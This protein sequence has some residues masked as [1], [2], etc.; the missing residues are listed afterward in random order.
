MGRSGNADQSVES[1]AWVM[2]GREEAAAFW[3][4]RSGKRGG[5]IQEPA[6]VFRGA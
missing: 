4:R 6:M 1:D 5:E 2:R 3:R